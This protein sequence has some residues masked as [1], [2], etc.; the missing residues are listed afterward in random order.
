MAT[1]LIVDD[2]FGIVEVITVAL[3][4]EG[5]RVF[6]AVNGRQGLERLAE[7]EVDLVLL[8]FM[9]PVLDGP[10]MYRSM[11]MDPALRMIPV[12]V[13]TSLDE[14]RVRQEYGDSVGYLRKPFSIGRLSQA[15]ERMLREGGRGRV[16]PHRL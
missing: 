8:D 1:V 2:E 16:N 5:H 3:E 12:V 4:E 7:T 15:V 11:Q 6:G 10:G 9:M 14:A 13:M